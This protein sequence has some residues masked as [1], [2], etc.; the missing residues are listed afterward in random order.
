MHCHSHTVNILL[1]CSCSAFETRSQCIVLAGWE[2]AV[3]RLRL[4]SNV[5]QSSCLCLQSDGITGVLHHVQLQLFHSMKKTVTW[6]GVDVLARGK[7]ATN[8]QVAELF[9]SPRCHLQVME[10]LWSPP[11]SSVWTLLSSAFKLYRHG[12]AD[13]VQWLSACLECTKP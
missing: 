12:F 13:L 11:W 7:L 3:C 5:S 2:L 8:T 10:A 4:S 9:T 1:F 6:L